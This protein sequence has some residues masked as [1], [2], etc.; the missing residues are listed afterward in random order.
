MVSSLPFAKSGDRS[1]RYGAGASF[2]ASS[3]RCG[4]MVP[5]GQEIL[6][7]CEKLMAGGK[8]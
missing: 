3:V 5:T 2:A 6:A 4:G 1:C 8:N 7:Q